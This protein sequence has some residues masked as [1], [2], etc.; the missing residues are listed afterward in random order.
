[1]KNKY[2][3]I[4]IT[5]C[6][7]FSLRAQLLLPNMP[8]IIGDTLTNAVGHITA[9]EHDSAKKR[10]YIAG[11]F[12]RV[13]SA[14][15]V[16]FAVID[17]S[18]GNVLNTLTNIWIMEQALSNIRVKMKLYNNKLYIGG[19]IDPSWQG[20]LFSINLNDSSITNISY[21]APLS[22][23]EV[24][25]NKI[26]TSGIFYTGQPDEFAVKELDLVGNIL[27][28]KSIINTTSEHLSSLAVRNNMLYVGGY[29]TS[30]GGVS[31]N[32]LAKVDLNTHTIT[33]WQLNPQPG[34]TAQ[35]TCYDVNDIVAYPNDVLVNVGTAVCGTP[36]NNVAGYSI[37]TGNLNT[38]IQ[39]IPYQ[40]DVDQLGYEN[41]TAFW[42]WNNSGLKLYSFQGY[43]SSFAAVSNTPGTTHLRK[44]GYLFS[45]G[46]FTT[47]QGN[48]HKG[49]GVFCLAPVKPKQQSVFA[50]AC[51]GQNIFYLVTPV[52]NATSYN[53]S[54]TGT[55][56]SIS[57]TGSS[58]WLNFSQSAT[59]GTLQV[60]ANSY[61]GAISDTL[62]IPFTVYPNP[63]VNAGP[64]VR[65]TCSNNIDTLLGSSSTPNVSYAWY[66]PG[67]NSSSAQNQLFSTTATPGN[68]VLWVTENTSGCKSKDTAV[69]YFDTLPPTLNHNLSYGW[70]N[71][72]N[73]VVTM[74]AAP[75]Y[76]G[77]NTL[78]WT[79]N[80]FSQS[81]PANVTVSGIYTLTI[82]SG[83]ND[84]F[85]TD[86]FFVSG[87]TTPPNI[88]AP[89]ALD[90]L[91]CLRDSVQLPASSTSIN[92]LVYWTNGN[93]DTLLNNSYTF[94]S[95]P[96]IAHAYDTV[97]FCTNQ[98]LAAVNQYTTPPIVQL[99]IGNFDIN[100]SYNTQILNGSSPNIGATL[101]WSNA[102]GFI[103]AN[104]ATITQAGTYV[105][106]ATHPQNGCMAKDS[107]IVNLL[108]TLDINSSADTIIC[109]GT[110]AILSAAPVGGTP[111]F[112]Y[113]WNNG[114]GN[115]QTF[116]VTPTD[117]TEYFVTITDNVGCVGTDTV[118]VFV[119]APVSDSVNTFQ[120][121]DPNNPSGQVQAYGVGGVPP[122]QFSLNGGAWQSSGVFGNLTFGTYTVSVKDVLGCSYSFYPV[123]D[124][125]SVM[126][127]PDF[128][129][130]TT[131]IQGDT[132][133]LVD[134]SNP[135]PDSVKWILPAGSSII[136]TNSFAP[137]VV[138]TDSG[139]FQV[140]MF[141]WFGTCQMQLTKN[142]TITLPDTSMANS[143][144]GNGIASLN[145][146]PNPNNGAFTVD[147]TF[148]KKQSFGLFIFDALGNELKRL[149][150]S[151]TDS[152]STTISLNSP[153]PGTY[154]FKVIA[155]YDSETRAFI[156]NQQ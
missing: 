13:G 92:A 4:F 38:S 147:V 63:T 118:I 101:S 54:Y 109:N 81:N 7:S 152:A 17:L 70:L 96:Y 94:L 3:L 91:T 31:L 35:P 58:A 99:P 83:L 59:S 39:T 112:I 46:S 140:T 116:S 57:G 32:N 19:D 55:G 33:N 135:R 154:V 95:G 97:N 104:P 144:N 85:A 128:I 155:E 139:A 37:A 6:F 8:A 102:S 64:D 62:K 74:D 82:T 67:Y 93:G 12:Q 88:S 23:F 20:Y 86:T 98:L 123:I 122:Y 21:D 40:Y 113:S 10:L 45:G 80:S 29:F 14:N 30:F 103:S 43:V 16:G 129:L 143:Y 53:W 11:D 111:S 71:C 150:Y 9:F 18:T 61:C 124:S 68:Y 22:D 15:R 134:I 90:T 26:Y 50:K 56:C 1:M 151:E 141:A 60:S 24:Y 146:Y 75:L 126:P 130:S 125:S 108:N 100:C 133:V 76:P 132:F 153:A 28:Q 5:F 120:P 27:W 79:G 106:T 72:L 149:S 137:Q 66:G 2:L 156:I 36:A 52:K 51:H 34:P 127:A 44:A 117:T 115:S 110:S 41:D 105:L 107:L 87:N 42:Y 78:H 47:M 121:C 131:Q 114:A 49:L 65:F 138:H 48:A 119:P 145:L 73:N 136:N 89:T 77:N 148:Y 69:V 25:N 84:C 142:I